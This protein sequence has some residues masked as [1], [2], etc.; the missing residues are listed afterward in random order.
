MSRFLLISVLIAM[1]TF[2]AAT[3]ASAPAARNT[4]VSMVWLLTNPQTYAEKEITVSGYLSLEFEDQRLYLDCG[5][6]RHRE[7]KNAVW[8]V[9]PGRNA[10]KFKKFQGLYVTVVGRFKPNPHYFADIPVSG[11]AGT[12]RVQTYKGSPN[13]TKIPA[14]A[15]VA[16][17][18]LCRG[19]K[20]KQLHIDS[21]RGKVAIQVHLNE[22]DEGSLVHL[23][24]RFAERER[25]TRRKGE[26]VKGESD[27]ATDAVWTRKDG[28]AIAI[29]AG[30]IKK[31]GFYIILLAKP[32]GKR[33]RSVAKKL[34]S[35]L[36]N[37][38]PHAVDVKDR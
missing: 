2:A 3:V 7:S 23:L 32:D 24:S 36:R 14:R 38:W 26:A 4:D 1:A 27:N 15:G 17:S 29:L 11:P 25:F 35:T 6:Y 33:W 21:P 22:S 34:E 19:S 8:L 30:N 31:S 5:S 9:F 20:P 16:R 12:V 18:D 13:I 10:S 37:R 28:L